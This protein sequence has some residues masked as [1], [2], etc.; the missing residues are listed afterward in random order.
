MTPET[1][2]IEADIGDGETRRLFLG[3]DEL[4][5]IEQEAGAGFYTLYLAFSQGNVSIEQVSRVLRLALIG[6]GMDPEK[7]LSLS[8]YYARPPRPLKTAYMTA[9]KV[10]EASWSGYGTR[11]VRASDVAAMTTDEI[12]GVIRAMEA[13]FIR[14]GYNVDLSGLSLA[15]LA[16]LHAK[17]FGAEKPPAPDEEM[18]HAIKRAAGKAKS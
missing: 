14:S 5:L 15:E 6:G 12:D 16:R 3:W 1:P 9:H 10:M 13:N 7:A 18:F 11:K 17:V 2:V 4:R 8:Q